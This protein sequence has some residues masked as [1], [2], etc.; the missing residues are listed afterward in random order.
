[1]V[2]EF[3]DFRVEEGRKRPDCFDAYLGELSVS[4]LLRPLVPKSG[5]GIVE[6][7]GGRHPV[8]DVGPY[9]RCCAFRLERYVS[10]LSILE[11][12][13]LFFDDV[14][15]L[16]DGP[17]EEVARLESGSPDLTITVILEEMSRTPLYVTPLGDFVR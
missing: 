6:F 13:H 3:Y 16:T 8:L 9:Y 12:V 1:M 17:C 2:S 5:G 14:C 4:A 11:R 10:S 15:C 7:G